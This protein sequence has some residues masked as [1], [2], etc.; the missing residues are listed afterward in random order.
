MGNYPQLYPQRT[1]SGSKS[2]NKYSNKNDSGFEV[3]EEGLKKFYGIG[4]S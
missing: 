3:T 4:G 1:E 2:K